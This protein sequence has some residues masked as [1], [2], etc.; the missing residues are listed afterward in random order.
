MALS[1]RRPNMLRYNSWIGQCQDVLASSPFGLPLDKSI[2]GWVKL[3]HISEEIATS[4]SF[5]DPGNMV[6]LSESRAPLMLKGF[7]KRLEIWK[8]GFD[9]EGRDGERRWTP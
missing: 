2:V 6:G 1:V 5:D 9:S 3:L 8:K 7:E 4:F